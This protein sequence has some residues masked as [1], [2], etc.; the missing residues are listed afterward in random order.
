MSQNSSIFKQKT[1]N[2]PNHNEKLDKIKSTKKNNENASRTEDIKEMMTSFI[3]SS[4]NIFF[5]VKIK[6]KKIKKKKER[7]K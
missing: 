5:W 1:N 4:T 2:H 6:N 7:K 3:R